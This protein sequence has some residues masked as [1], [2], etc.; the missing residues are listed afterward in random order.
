MSTEQLLQPTETRLTEADQLWLARFGVDPSWQDNPEAVADINGLIELGSMHINGIESEA[1]PLAIE[2]ARER[3]M[4]FVG[5][6]NE[7]IT[8]LR[9]NSPRLVPLD[10]FIQTQRT[11][12]SAGLDGPRVVSLFPRVMGLAPESVSAKIDN[13]DTL[14]LDAS[15]VINSQPSLISHAP[16]SIELK[17]NV[18]DNLGLNAT[19]VI[20]GFPA[21]LTRSPKYIKQKVN[22]M[23]GLGL[24]AI[25]VINSQPSVI[26]YA[27]ESIEKRVKNL[28]KL[29]LDASKVIVGLPSILSKS[30]QTIHKRLNLIEGY[31]RV[32]KWR[33][34]AKD[35]V[36]T[37][38]AI[39]AF[40]R[41]KLKVFA[42]IAA[43]HIF[44]SERQAKSREVANALFVP[45]EQYIIALAEAPDL[46]SNIVDLK[47]AARRNSS[48]REQRRREAQKSA[49]SGQLGKIGMAYL[50]Y[51]KH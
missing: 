29:G 8:K 24:D 35:L 11:M 5:I 42:R 49:K 13:L 43:D 1:S 51:Q 21:V 19:K 47:N 16:E 27:P 50:S 31:A 41:K 33:G 2:E 45:L 46:K 36:E 44:A 30:E 15:K 20:N 28:D 3:F 14:G 17:F 23:E 26:S 6:E 39:L 10:T 4:A 22:F 37:Y 48:S 32:L 9:I 25:K 12:Y 34:S 40:D 7:T 18:M 38:P